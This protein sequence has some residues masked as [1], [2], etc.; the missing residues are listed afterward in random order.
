[1]EPAKEG[2]ATGRGSFTSVGKPVFALV[3]RSVSR[4]ARAGA[5]G[6]CQAGALRR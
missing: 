6:R 2:D 4:P 3:R 1:M 5:K